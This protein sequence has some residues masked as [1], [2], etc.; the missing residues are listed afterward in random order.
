MGAVDRAA[1]SRVA[2]R[3]HGGLI[4]A[5]VFGANCGGRVSDVV[6]DAPAGGAGW[7]SGASGGAKS[8][9]LSGTVGGASR[10]D[11]ATCDG[12]VVGAW[13]VTSSS[14]TVNGEFDLSSLGLDCPHAF[15]KDSPFDVFGN[16][17][18]YSD[19][20]YWDDTTT[21]GSAKLL[22]PS[23]CLQRS[24]TV[25]SCANM[26]KMLLALGFMFSTCADAAAGGC[27]C[28]VYVQRFGG[29]GVISIWPSRSGSYWT[30]GTEVTIVDGPSTVYSYCVSDNELSMNPLTAM[31]AMTGTIVFQRM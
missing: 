25:T 4:L 26:G 19:G 21:V 7:V 8:A 3:G 16:W 27:V 2:A 18:A 5:A 28:D 17:T 30:S 29:L 6:D 14:L 24:G 11:V 13:K 20:T 15:M 10:I 12:D 23:S 22:L 1:C 31:P 9:G